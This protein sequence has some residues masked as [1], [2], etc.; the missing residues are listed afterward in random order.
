MNMKEHLGKII[1]VAVYHNSRFL[2]RVR[3][4]LRKS[5]IFGYYISSNGGSILIFTEDQITDIYPEE[6][7]FVPYVE[8]Q[9]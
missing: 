2:C 6:G 7:D 4:E 1:E 8:V 3:G 9:I 5:L